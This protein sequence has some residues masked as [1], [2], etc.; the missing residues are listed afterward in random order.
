M[1]I[2]K[3]KRREK[4]T[5]TKGFFVFTKI[6]FHMFVNNFHIFYRKFYK[7]DYKEKLWY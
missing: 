1:D 3:K 6:D 7:Q 2:Q 5:T 4:K